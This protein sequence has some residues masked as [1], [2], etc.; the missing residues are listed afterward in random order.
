LQST[1]LLQE[2]LL[3]LRDA[4]MFQLEWSLTLIPTFYLR[5]VT[6]EWITE[7][8]AVHWTTVC[9]SISQWWT[10]SGWM[11]WLDSAMISQ[12]LIIHAM[13]PTINALRLHCMMKCLLTMERYTHG[14]TLIRRVL[15]R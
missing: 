13:L 10:T 12:L 7:W 9:A 15:L 14:C 5:I 3:C 2:T 1:T 8:N 6:T 11:V 4:R